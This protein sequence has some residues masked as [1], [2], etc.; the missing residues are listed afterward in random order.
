M[1]WFKIFVFL[2]LNNFSRIN[3]LNWYPLCTKKRKYCFH[4]LI[5]WWTFFFLLKWSSAH[6]SWKYDIDTFFCSICS[7]LL[8]NILVIKLLC[9]SIQN[10]YLFS[11]ACNVISFDLNLVIRMCFVS[12]FCQK[13]LNP[14][15]FAV[16][17]GACF[18]VCRRFW[19]QDKVPF[20][21]HYQLPCVLLNLTHLSQPP[22]QFTKQPFRLT[23]GID[24]GCFFC[25]SFLIIS[26]CIKVLISYLCG[27]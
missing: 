11:F 7:H 15:I 20:Q 16:D 3:I 14:R 12:G 5:L 27:I 25:S 21:D 2:Y 23:F 19:K 22:F 8:S 1:H 9:W 24:I 6:K 18:S 17:I 13:Y 26:R 4:Q 10:N